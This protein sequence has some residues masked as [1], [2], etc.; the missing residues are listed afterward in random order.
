MDGTGNPASELGAS[1]DMDLEG[2][3]RTYNFYFTKSA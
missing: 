3:L 1:E 2:K